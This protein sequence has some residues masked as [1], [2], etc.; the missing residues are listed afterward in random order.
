[1]NDA[2]DSRLET[3]ELWSSL[4]LV[5]RVSKHIVWKFLKNMTLKFPSLPGSLMRCLL[6]IAVGCILVLVI[7]SHMPPDLEVPFDTI[8]LS[9]VWF[10]WAKKGAQKLPTTQIAFIIMWSLE[11]MYFVSLYRVGLGIE[12]VHW[13]ALGT[14]FSGLSVQYILKTYKSCLA[15]S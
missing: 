9:Q 2:P 4:P 11:S 15:I 7:L 3:Q 12:S 8:S 13:Y 6:M 5:R 14:L 1:M 10:Y